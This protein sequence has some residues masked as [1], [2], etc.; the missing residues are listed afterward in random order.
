MTTLRTALEH[1]ATTT[2]FE[3]SDPP[4]DSAWERCLAELLGGSALR[5]KA[6]G[7]SLD[8]PAQCAA[9]STG[10]LMAALE[11]IPRG[12]Q[13]S[14]VLHRFATWWVDTFGDDPAPAWNRSLEEFRDGLRAIRGLGPETVDRL[15][16]FGAGLPVVPIDRAT[17][18]VLVRHGWLDLP[19]SDDEAQSTLLAAAGSEIGELQRTV[20]RLHAVGTN[21][22]GRI[23][24]CEACPLQACLP[25]SGPLHPDAC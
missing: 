25:A 20:R 19:L 15:L 18:R 17:L 6:H 9:A 13:K 7:T 21:Y 8:S 14:S 2:T 22:C 11:G 16:L 10:T 3:T 12:P 1:L 5:R 23:P 24:E 4:D